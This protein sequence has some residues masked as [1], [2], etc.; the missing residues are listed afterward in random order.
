MAINHRLVRIH[1]LLDPMEGRPDGAWVLEYRGQ[2]FLTDPGG[3]NPEPFTWSGQARHVI[4]SRARTAPPL[5]G[6]D[7]ETREDI[8]RQLRI[9]PALVEFVQRSD[10]TFPEPIAT[11]SDGPIWDAEA[12]ERWA[13]TST[14]LSLPLPEIT[15]SPHS[16]ASKPP[17]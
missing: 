3:G 12:I 1:L 9:N 6:F 14:A 13:P 4:E 16:G 17:R 15:E 10:P 8:A 5:K 11:F 7:V 2:A